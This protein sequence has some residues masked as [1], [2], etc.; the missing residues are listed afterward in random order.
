MRETIPAAD[1]TMQT[2]FERVITH[3]MN[4]LGLRLVTSGR[5][6]F[7]TRRVGESLLKRP[8]L[9]ARAFIQNQLY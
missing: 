3:Q 8:L 4:R 1:L 2:V 9:S 5:L 7:V 6:V